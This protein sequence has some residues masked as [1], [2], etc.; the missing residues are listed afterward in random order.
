M[1]SWKTT[2]ALEPAWSCS[3]SFSHIPYDLHR[4]AML[5]EF[6]VFRCTIPLVC[7]YLFSH[8]LCILGIYFSLTNENHYYCSGY[9]HQYFFV[10]ICVWSIQCF[11]L[12]VVLLA[13]LLFTAFFFSSFLPLGAGAVEFI[14]CHAEI[15]VAFVEEKKIV[16]VNNVLSSSMLSFL[17]VST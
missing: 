9:L 1:L 14:I 6:T 3:S 16:E 15:E 8:L 5:M 11:L 13:H 10:G 7:N 12:S 2:L 4:L 17:L